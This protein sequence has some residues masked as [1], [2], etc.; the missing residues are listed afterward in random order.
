MRFVYSWLKMIRLGFLP[1]I[2]WWSAGGGAQSA[3]LHIVE[4][5]LTFVAVKKDEADDAD[6][7]AD[8]E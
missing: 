6:G 1:A 3:V 2:R 4:I 5:L 7:G 8:R